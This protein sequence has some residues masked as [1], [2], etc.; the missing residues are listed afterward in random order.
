MEGYKSENIKITH[1]VSDVVAGNLIG[2]GLLGVAIDTATG[3][4]WRLEPDNIQ[5]ALRPLLPGEH[6]EE[7]ERLCEET[8]HDKLQA[9]DR[10]KEAHLITENQYIVLRNITIHCVS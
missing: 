5:V 8:L 1:V 4:I 9:L 7:A 3:S 10:L 2:F 6:F